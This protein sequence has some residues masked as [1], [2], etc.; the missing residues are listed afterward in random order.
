VVDAVNA[1][2]PPHD[3]E[4]AVTDRLP[5]LVSQGLLRAS[6][7]T[8]SGVA[9]AD[10]V[11]VIVPLVIDSQR[12]ID[13]GPIDAA[14][15][16]IGAGLGSG[17]LVIYETTVPVGVTRTRL[18][19]RLAARSG[20]APESELYVAFSPERVLVG[21]VLEDLR[22]YPKVV[23]GIGPASTD[24]AVAFYR[25]A[26]DDGVEIRQVASAEAAEM[27]KLAETTYRDVNIA[28]ANEL[29]RYAAARDIDIAEVIAA[30]NSQPYSHLHRPGVGVGGHCIPVYP[31]F[32]F[33]DD[34]TMQIPPLARTVNDGMAHW[35][36][37]RIA[38]RL[39]SL[40]DV[41][42]LVLGVAYRADVR[43]D[44][45]SAADR[46]R[47]ELRDAGSRVYAHDPYFGGAHLESAGFIPW[48][49][50]TPAS[51][52]VAILQADHAAYRTFDFAAVPGLELVVDGRNALEP[53]AVRQAGIEYMGIGRPATAS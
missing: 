26:L 37:D 25:A 47:R 49:L 10:V 44:A 28:L 13:Y 23:G 50:S 38:Q 35:V 4:R 20:L 45:F 5:Q 15:D 42:V 16:E 18:T 17:C 24:R 19:A 29:A 46:L 39:G 14:T 51:V 9:A 31:Y 34:D 41:P 27:T 30:A 48:D 12:R 53:A 1:G 3:D 21:R 7:D 22:R 6:T 32:L 11:V 33:T 2:R 40:R 8:R 43:E 36:V 52:R